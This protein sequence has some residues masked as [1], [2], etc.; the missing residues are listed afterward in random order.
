MRAGKQRLWSNL[1]RAA[2]QEVDAVY[3]A[4]PPLLR[5][6]ARELPVT[7]EPRPGRALVED[8]LEEDTLGL[9]VGE[10]FSES[11]L[12]MEGVPPQIILFLENI[13]AYAAGDSA[14][15]REEVRITYVHELGHHLGLD[16]DDLMVR[17]LD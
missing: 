13:W 12:G 1:Q 5:E 3:R 2:V 15:Y 8:G 16:E 11:A 10:A 6:R 4:L 14:T 9:Y 7:Y 17:D